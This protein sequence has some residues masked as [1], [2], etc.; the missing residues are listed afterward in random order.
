M[1]DQIRRA[2]ICAVAVA[3]CFRGDGQSLANPI[4]VIP[5]ITLSWSPVP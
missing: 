5:M 1:T 4:G 3:E 2:D